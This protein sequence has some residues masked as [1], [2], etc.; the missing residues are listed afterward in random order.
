MEGAMSPG[1]Y[2]LASGTRPT[3]RCPK[4]RPTGAAGE[5]QRAVLRQ[6]TSLEISDTLSDMGTRAAAS[7]AY[8]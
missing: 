4:Q 7:A 6:N 5:L 3:T 2:R 1:E 8:R